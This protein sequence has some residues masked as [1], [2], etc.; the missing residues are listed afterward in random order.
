MKHRLDI[1][2]YLIIVISFL[3]LSHF[4]FEYYVTRNASNFSI[5]FIILLLICSL[6]LIK[7]SHSLIRKGSLYRIICVFTVLVFIT[8]IPCILESTMNAA[9]R[10]ILHTIA[11][12][13]GFILGQTLNSELFCYKDDEK[14]NWSL[15]LILP[16]F[17]VTYRYLSIVFVDPDSL[18]FVILLF[19][20]VFSLRK[21]ILKI[22]I[23]ILVGVVCAIS[24]KRSI[25][26]AY[27][28]GLL[29]FI[30]QYSF[31]NRNRRF[32]LR[33]IVIFASLIIVLFWLVSSNQD[34]VDQIILR[35]QGI[36]DDNGSGRTDLYNVLLDSFFDSS[37]V[38]QL[39]GHGYRSSVS[40]LGGV[41]PHND[42]L[43]ILYDFG[44]IPLFVYIIILL[45]LLRLSVG[46]IKKQSLSNATILLAVSVF[47]LIVLGA[48][49]NIFIDTLFIFS[50]FLCIGVAINMV[51]FNSNYE[52]T[53]LNH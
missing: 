53:F 51:E 47:N 6:F 45:R 23:F 10:N 33:S 34:V 3:L 5:Y 26:I 39:L 44:A 28:I 50:C 46:Y 48:L 22:I 40:V 4:N 15:L 41:P 19:P 31:F 20:L 52:S 9:I 49:N 11:I 7:F 18:F 17:Y 32:S 8:Q 16:I 1:V 27:S 42:I 14:C 13:I 38:N 36:K 24:A 35:F 21:D 30:F 2:L 25:L 29:L 37:I 12:P 43:E